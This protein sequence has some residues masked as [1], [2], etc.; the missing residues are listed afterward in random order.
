MGL[1]ELYLEKKAKIESEAMAAIAKIEEKK[2]DDVLEI[3]SM[4]MSLEAELKAAEDKGFDLGV[5]Q[6][7]IPAG[8]KIYTEADLQAEKELAVK[9]FLEQVASLE[10]TVAELQAEKEKLPELIQAAVDLKVVEI[11]A[12][13]EAAQVDDAA[14]LAKYKKV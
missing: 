3:D 2:A 13:F 4:V 14:F 11:V 9:P 5:A 8:D 7:G 12:D 10:V 1:K 6:A